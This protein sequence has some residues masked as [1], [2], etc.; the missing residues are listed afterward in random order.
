MM[1][2]IHDDGKRRPCMIIVPGGGYSVVSPTEGEIVALEFYK[3]GYNA[4]VCTYSTNLLRNVPLKTQPMRDLSRAI[5]MIR[6]NAAEYYVDSEKVVIC[7]FSAGGHLCGSI[8]VH[9][10]DIEDE[11]KGYNQISNR[12]DAAILAYPV[13]TSEAGKSH[14]E[15]FHALLGQNPL[16]EELKYFSLERHVTETTSPCFIWQTAADELVPVENSCLFAQSCQLHKV[17]YAYHVFYQGKHGLSLGNEKW[18]KGQFGELYTL[19]QLGNIVA[20][21]QEQGSPIPNELSGLQKNS[22]DEIAK[23]NSE[24]CIWPELAETWLENIFL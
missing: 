7:G 10:D 19:E 5:R 23:E 8:C 2:Y 12:P 14:E 15:S 6:K 4:F 11:D 9:Y 20:F 1:S 21:L 22:Q 13:I 3:R 16:K 24:V 17:P 18:E